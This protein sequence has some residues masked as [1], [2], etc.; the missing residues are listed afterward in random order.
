MLTNAQ[1]T[2]AID[3]VALYRDR[4]VPISGTTTPKLN[5]GPRQLNHFNT[6]RP[7]SLVIETRSQSKLMF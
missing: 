5:R 3:L 1:L 6:L 2:V 4:I 7:A